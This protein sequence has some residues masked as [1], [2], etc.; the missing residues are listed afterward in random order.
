MKC[1]D[2]F[3]VDIP[4]DPFNTNDNN[5]AAH[6]EPPQNQYHPPITSTQIISRIGTMVSDSAY[7]TLNQFNMDQMVPTSYWK[8]MAKFLNRKAQ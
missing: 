1:S 2:Q 4:N 5:N 7:N 3:Q 8:R 6:Y